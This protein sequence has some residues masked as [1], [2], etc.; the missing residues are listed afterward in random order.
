MPAIS[1]PIPAQSTNPFRVPPPPPG[2]QRRQR[3]WFLFCFAVAAHLAHPVG[4]LAPLHHHG[5]PCPAP[6]R[7]NAS[8]FAVACTAPPF[9]HRTSPIGTNPNHK[10]SCHLPNLSGRAACSFFLSLFFPERKKER[11]KEP[12]KERKKKAKAAPAPP[13]QVIHGARAAS[14]PQ[15]MRPAPQKLWVGSA[16]QPAQAKH[17]DRAE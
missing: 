3:G 17:P 7:G 13:H 12:K 1:R 9:P 15:G 6:A 11:K 14:P 8:F 4:H 10:T 2:A 5:R 16:E